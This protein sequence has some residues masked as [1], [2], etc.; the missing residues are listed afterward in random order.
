MFS[1]WENQAT[2][3][4]SSTPKWQRP[5]GQ[6]GLKKNA[7]SL[8]ISIFRDYSTK[9]LCVNWVPL[10]DMIAI[11]QFTY[12]FPCFQLSRHCAFYTLK[13]LLYLVA[14]KKVGQSLSCQRLNWIKNLTIRLQEYLLKQ[15]I[16]T[17]QFVIVFLVIVKF[18]LVG[19]NH[20]YCNG[21]VTLLEVTE[22]FWFL[23]RTAKRFEILSQ[24]FEVTSAESFN[25]A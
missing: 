18:N 25:H 20:Q 6:T 15:E 3:E 16:L 7:E 5:K 12:F 13:V 19:Y 24:N 23:S 8:R 2:N 21:Y 22:S 11:D 17:S 9:V 14:K 4:C 1:F 10:N